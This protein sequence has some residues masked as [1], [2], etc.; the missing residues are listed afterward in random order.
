MVLSAAAY[1]AAGDG[2][3]QGVVVALDT[4]TD[5]NDRLLGAEPM[6]FTATNQNHYENV[7]NNWLD[8]PSCTVPNIDT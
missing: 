7:G 4:G 5:V 3:F 2:D 6:L 8:L 1:A